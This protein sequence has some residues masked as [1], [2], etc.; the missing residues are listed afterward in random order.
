[1]TAIDL[2]KI[3]VPDAIG[4]KTFE[5]I[6][7]ELKADFKKALPKYSTLDQEGDPINKLLQTVATREL[8]LRQKINTGV[9]AVMLASATGADLD[10]IG[11]LFN[12]SRKTITPADNDATPPTPAVLETDDAFRERIQLA[13]E[14]YSVAGSIGAYI[15]HGRNAHNDVK[16]VS[17]TTPSAGN[18]TVTVLSSQGNGIPSDDVIT[19]VT[20]KL[21]NQDVRPLGDNVTV[22]KASVVSFEVNATLTIA[23]GPDASVVKTKAEQSLNAYLK[24]RHALGKTVGLDGLYASLMVD[25]VDKVKLTKPTADVTTTSAQAPYTNSITIGTA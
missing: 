4:T 7:A 8:Q 16:D 20:Q 14:G 22:Q 13:P 21:S 15:F 10:N 23:S 24:Q 3:P 6:L 12:V 1:M 19:A 11:A 5:T 25:G 9:S 17:V 18:I 2:S